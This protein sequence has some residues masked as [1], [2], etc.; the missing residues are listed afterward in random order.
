MKIKN[1]CSF[2]IILFLVLVAVPDAPVQFL[3]ENYKS[4]PQEVSFYWFYCL[5]A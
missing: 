2:K 5:L 1:I 3:N 4:L